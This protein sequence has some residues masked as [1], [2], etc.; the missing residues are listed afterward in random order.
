MGI[1][2]TGAGAGAGAGG[3]SGAYLLMR[4][5]EKRTIGGAANILCMPIPT[6]SKTAR[7]QAQPMAE[8]RIDL[9][10]PDR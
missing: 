2:Y 1:F 3:Y 6:P 7:R 10:P 4:S 8:F 5:S 9:G